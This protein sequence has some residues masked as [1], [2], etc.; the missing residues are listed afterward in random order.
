MRLSPS[1]GELFLSQFSFHESLGMEVAQFYCMVNKY[2]T[3]P[4]NKL[5][6]YVTLGYYNFSRSENWR[7]SNDKNQ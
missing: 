2:F 3:K 5:P 4:V 7:K 1:C 6:N